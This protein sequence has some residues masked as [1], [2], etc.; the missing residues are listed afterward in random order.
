MGR[1]EAGAQIPAM[2]H[3]ASPARCPHTLLGDT[4][5]LLVRRQERFCSQTDPPAPPWPGFSH[6]VSGAGVQ[7]ATVRAS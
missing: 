2:V 6:W 4:L 3:G 1:L 7:G 5:R